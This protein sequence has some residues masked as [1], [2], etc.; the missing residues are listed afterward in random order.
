MSEIYT[1]FFKKE[2]KPARTT[3]AASGLAAGAKLEIE[4]MAL[5]SSD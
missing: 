4:C 3:F 2:M 1:T 5:M